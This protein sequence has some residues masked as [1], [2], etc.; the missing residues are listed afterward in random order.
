VHKIAITA[1]SKFHLYP[2]GLCLDMQ[3]VLMTGR[4]KFV[5]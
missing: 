5:N 1:K 3:N 2:A 4:F